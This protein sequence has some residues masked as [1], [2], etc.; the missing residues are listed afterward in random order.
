VIKASQ[1]LSGEIQLDQLLSTLMQVVMEN[2]GADKCALILVKGDR[3]VLQA[4]ETANQLALVES[5]PVEESPDIPQ[6]AINYVKRKSETLV[7]N[8]ITVETILAADPYFIRQQ[9]RSLMCTH[10]INQG[11]LIGLLYLENNLTTG[12]F[13][14]DRLEILNLLTS[15]A[16]I[17]IENSLLYRQLEDYSHTL[18]QK[19]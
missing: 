8:D 14:P 15:Q 16:A 6:S 2:A 17:S 9:P 1:A 13:T 7:I 18:E 12:A 10:I 4:M 3:L 19:V 5:I 11:Q